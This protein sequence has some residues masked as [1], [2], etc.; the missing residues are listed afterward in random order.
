MKTL[1]KTNALN[2]LHRMKK[3]HQEFVKINYEHKAADCETCPT[4]GA[5]CVDAHFVNVHITRLEAVAICETLEKFGEEKQ[6]EIFER[7]EETV[8]K[9]KLSSAEDT[10]ARTFIC[11]MFEKKIG[12]LVHQEA[13]P[14]SCIQHGCYE[15]AEDLPPEDLLRKAEKRTERLN[16]RTFGN[17][18][19]WLPLPV[20]LDSLNPFKKQ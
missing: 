14:A 4:K 1:T 2:D 17:A 16:T 5:C 7:V 19:N 10:F 15:N 13:K 20:W 11:P 12:C 6:R 3:A 18:W 8:K 9:F